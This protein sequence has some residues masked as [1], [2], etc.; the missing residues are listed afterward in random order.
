MAQVLLQK[1]SKTP[2]FQINA[3][4]EVVETVTMRDSSRAFPISTTS[5]CGLSGDLPPSCSDRLVTAMSTVQPMSLLTSLSTFIIASCPFP[6]GTALANRGCTV[7]N[8]SASVRSA[9]G[10]AMRILGR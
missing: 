5:C 7:A 8:M 4:P 2:C 10:M 6:L 9:T 3:P 1:D